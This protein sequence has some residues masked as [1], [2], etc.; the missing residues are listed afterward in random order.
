MTFR[1]LIGSVQ[2]ELKKTLDDSSPSLAQI[3]FWCTFFINKARSMKVQQ[4]STGRYKTIF[5]NVPILIP[6]VSTTNLIAGRKYII[7]PKNILD[8]PNDGGI[9]YICY[10]DFAGACLPSFVGGMFERTTQNEAES[11]T[12]SPYTYPKPDKPYYYLISQNIC[13]LLGLECITVPSLEVGLITSFDP[14]TDCVMDENMDL[15]EAQVAD[16]YN[17]VLSLGRF[18][19]IVPENKTNTATDNTTSEEAPKQKITP[20]TQ[21][22]TNAE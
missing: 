4:E 14:F 8:L 15:D 2:V 17:S 3:A 7:L 20:I 10:N 22:Q 6:T 12:Y 16:V 18:S 1:N 21:P 11:L 13:Y 19:L 9:D 5:P